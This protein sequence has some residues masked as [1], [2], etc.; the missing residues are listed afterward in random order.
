MQGCG[1]CLGFWWCGVWGFSKEASVGARAP[2][3][4]NEALEATAA[5]GELGSWLAKVWGFEALCFGGQGAAGHKSGWGPITG[6]P[7][8]GK[9]VRITWKLLD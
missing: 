5:I 9:V 4:A 2:S 8:A 6:P 3:G 1:W 7:Q